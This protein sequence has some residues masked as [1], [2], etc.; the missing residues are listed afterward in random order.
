MARMSRLPGRSIKYFGWGMQR[1]Q[2]WL[3]EEYLLSREITMLQEEVR[4]FYYGDIQAIVTSPTR[5]FAI[6]NWLAGSLVGFLAACLGLAAFMGSNAAVALAAVAASVPMAI[7]SGNLI[8]GPTCKTTLYTA[9]AEAPLYSLGR[10]RSTAKA[11]A[12]LLPFIDAAQKNAPEAA[13]SFAAPEAVESTAA[14]FDEPF[15]AGETTP[16]PDPLDP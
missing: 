10:Q 2:L 6:C 3:T 13:D 14:P 5:N 1:H 7:L 11:I 8:F 9:A 16:G 15:N 12:R 4:R